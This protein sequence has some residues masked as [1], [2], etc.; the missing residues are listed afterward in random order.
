MSK[1]KLAPISTAILLA[2]FGGAAWAESD[3]LSSDN[4]EM[5]IIHVTAKPFDTPVSSLPGTVQIIDQEAIQAQISLSADLSSLLANLV[6]SYGPETQMMSSTYQGFRGRKAIVMIDGV[7]VSNTLRDT[8]RVLSSISV[9]NIA[10]I[11]VIQ[12]AS[13]VYGNG[14]SAGVI[15]LITHQ[16]S[17]EGMAF[18]SEAK[19]AGSIHDADSIGYQLSQRISGTQGQFNYLA[20][21]NWR[22]SGT[23]F[24]G[25][26]TQ[27]PSDPAGRGGQGEL[28]DFDALVK[29]GY[30]FDDDSTMALN[31]HSRKLENQLSF[32]R[33]TVF[34]ET[35]V[36]DTSKPFTG[37]APY[38]ENK[39]VQ[40]TYNAPSMGGHQVNIELSA[41]ESENTQ[42]NKVLTQSKKQALRIAAQPL[43]LP[44]EQDKLTYGIDYQVDK[45][46]Q[47]SAKG[48]CEICNV[49][50]TN[51]AP[52][53]EYEFNQD[54]F[55]LQFGLRY[56]NFDLDVP[57]YLAT[58]RYG[59]TPFSGK[60]IEGG[61]LS[62]RKPV[63]NLGGVYRFE[64]TEIYASFSQGYG[65]G[66][67]RRL[68]SIDVAKVEQ[69]D[70]KMT[71]TEANNF[72]LGYRGQFDNL[73]FDI[74]LFYTQSERAQSYVDIL[75][76][77][78]YSTLASLD[79]R[80]VYDQSKTL[81]PD[82][83]DAVVSRDEKT[84]GVELLSSYAINDTFT[85]GGNFSYTQGE[86]RHPTNGWVKMNNA[87]ISPMKA[88]IFLDMNLND[89]F[90]GLLQ[91][92]YV[93]SR[94]EGSEIDLALPQNGMWGT[95]KGYSYYNAPTESYT[96]VDL[97]LFYRSDFGQFTLGIK[98]LFD[99]VYRPTYAQMGSGSVYG[100]IDL[101]SD[102]T[103]DQL[104]GLVRDYAFKD[105]YNAQGTTF[106]LGYQVNY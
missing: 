28:E 106:T 64:T 60:T 75:D 80:L 20:Q 38:S 55:M 34:D 73:S 10:R 16:A 63:F 4:G 5:E 54:S 77:V 45:T 85:L 36:V 3:Q 37:D 49:E 41:S 56:E 89:E 66:D 59:Y 44:R 8:S 50:Q 96:T 79:P 11:E 19:I 58:G 81:N 33:K 53:A 98:N 23:L 1:F 12:G 17:S 74:G 88:N 29:L 14:E 31:L 103:L 57:D 27:I 101:P 43:V 67:L 61:S 26:G 46:K 72:D 87:R 51:L 40:F 94:D 99:K 97:S 82:A 9:E 7:V 78:I 47:I 104:E 86:Y 21:L 52:F 92:N 22:D 30:L 100:G 70:D 25:E 68:R 90:G 18:W 71:P 91:V 39:Y 62:Y 102:P 6:P 24:D 93:G 83:I 95:F 69:Y 2:T 76:Q 13:A 84:Y 32:A 105:S 42:A 15:N 35:V 48:V 65:L